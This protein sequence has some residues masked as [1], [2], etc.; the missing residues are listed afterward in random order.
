MR[1]VRPAAII[2]AFLIIAFPI[3]P[4]L[5]S[6]QAPKTSQQK[7]PAP[8]QRQPKRPQRADALAPAINELLKL[9]PL[10]PQAPGEKD[11][12]NDDASSEKENK[13]PADDA[14]IKEL[15][16]YWSQHRDANAPKPSGKVRQRLLEAC[17]DRPE[18]T[19]DLVNFLPETTDTHDRLYK[20][21]KEDWGDEFNW[22]RNLQRWLQ[23]NSRYFRDDL[24]AA[25]RGEDVGESSPENSLRS[26]A[27]IDWEAARPMVE[28]FASAGNA[29]MAS[30]ALSLLYERSQAVGDSG[31]VEKFRALLKAIVVNRQTPYE[32]RQ[33]ALS[34]LT[35]TEWEGQENWVVSL[36]TETSLNKPGEDEGEGASGSRD[37]ST[38][39][40]PLMDNPERWLPVI[41]ALVGHHQR[42]A[43]QLAVECL[44]YHLYRESADK[45]LK[46]EIAQ[47]LAPCLTHPDWSAASGRSAF[48]HLLA[49]IQA[50]EL[51][52]GLIWVLEH[53]EDEDN[54]AAAAAALTQYRDPRANPALRR[55]LEKEE[56][57][58]RREKIVT[59][60]AEC[61]GLSDD[62]MAAAVEAYAKIVVTE[63]GEGEIDEAKNGDSEK[64]LS[65]QVSVGRILS[66]SETTHAT[67]GL[68]ARLIER[69][70]SLR[71][72]QPAVARQMLRGMEGAPLRIAEINL[73]ER[74]GA[75]WADTDALKLALEN[76]GSL[77]K[78]ATDELYSLIKQGGYA[79]GV[80]A[81]ILSDEREHRETLKG[82]DAKAQF[83]LLACGRY[84]RDKLPVELAGRLLGSPNRALANAVESYLE[85]EDSAEARRLVLARRRG[86]AYIL[87]DLASG[88]YGLYPEALRK[89]EEKMRKEI[90]GAAGLDAIYALLGLGF[91]G[92]VI[93]VRDRKAEISLY[94]V[95]GRRD[96]R[97]LTESEFEELKSFTSRQ[98]VEDLGPET[99][100][101]NPRRV[102]YEYLRLTK[103]GGRRIALEHMRRAPKNPTMHEEL[104]GLFYRLS[105]SG[106]FVT[107]Y[108]IEDKIPGVEVLLADKKQDAMMVCG[109]GRE[110]RVLVGEKWGEYR[111]GFAKAMP[112]WHEVSSGKLGKVTDEPAACPQL[113]MI[114]SFIKIRSN[115]LY[116]GNS[117]YMEIDELTRSGA[118][119][120]FVPTGIDAGVWKV[121]PGGEPERITSGSYDRPLVTPDGKWLVAIK[122]LGEGGEYSLQLVRHNLQ[123]GEEFQVK[124]ANHGNGLPV[125]YIAAHGKVLLDPGFHVKSYLGPINYLLDPETGS[126]QQVTGEFRPLMYRFVRELQPTG[127]PNEIWAAIHDSQKGATRIGRY[128]TRNFVFTPVIEAPGPVLSDSNFWV[129][130]DAGKI[131]FTYYGHLLRLPMPA[132]KK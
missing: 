29:R 80:A 24:I 100:D 60:L 27:R 59:A 89:W 129:D 131:W 118:A 45:K 64:P 21:F 86:E 66:E 39:L 84:L 96:V 92:V 49:G 31:Q 73:V 8:R 26:L 37:E 120:I 71:A 42:M 32:A 43:H 105:S 9:D 122:R 55:A 104:S 115:S 61:G 117:N 116:G 5:F 1:L 87:G 110:I 124:M 18:L 79:T 33:T 10:P 57:E 68:A 83:A 69:A 48:I 20:L 70:K 63:A 72:S 81:A 52:S 67:E 113:G 112:E 125:M 114:Q 56:N 78:S 101:Y 11:S 13:P 53:D 40:A 44:T 91:N 15:I 7:Q 62:E 93:R 98:E 109:E 74:I 51:L 35:K 41:G 123:T 127:N 95:E 38:V 30:M 22:K 12:D 17:E 36:F 6:Q 50:P 119:W 108:A 130:A 88:S 82:T 3:P 103:D 128:D 126:L 99:Y 47:K 75:G 111:R 102:R 77:Q 65:L 2:A 106:E 76:R 107:R 34:S 25:A 132:Q 4:S 97:L 85:V 16:T 28:I 121:E 23:G 19:F 14:P 54:R 90:K 46:K 94:D 58:D